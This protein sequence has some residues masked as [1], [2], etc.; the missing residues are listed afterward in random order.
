MGVFLFVL[1]E[2]HTN[3]AGFIPAPFSTVLCH[4]HIPATL[5]YF[6]FKVNN[7]LLLE[8]EKFTNG[9][10]GGSKLKQRP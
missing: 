5:L 3:F 8:V 9:E 7:C 1:N 10:R 2:V 4:C 6:F